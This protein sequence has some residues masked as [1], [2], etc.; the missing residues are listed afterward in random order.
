M[1]LRENSP[2]R[3]V[4]VPFVVPFSTTFAPIIGSPFDQ[5]RFRLCAFLLCNNGYCSGGLF[6]QVYFIVF[7][8]ITQIGIGN[9]FSNTWATSAS[10]T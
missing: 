5:Q 3:L 4:T 9:E 10:S 1:V 8:F 7:N 2:S 6:K